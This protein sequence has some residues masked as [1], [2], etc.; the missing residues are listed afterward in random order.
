MPSFAAC[1]RTRRP[2]WSTSSPRSRARRRA[3]AEHR[4]RRIRIAAHGRRYRHAARRLGVGD[5]RSHRRRLRRHEHGHDGRAA[6]PVAL[7]RG[8]PRRVGPGTRSLDVATGTGD[9][10]IELASRGGDVVGSD[11]STGMLER[12]RSKAPGLTWEQ[13]DAMA[14]PYPDDEFDAAT[15]GFGARNF[16]D[17]RAGLARDGPRGQ[18]RRAGRDPGDHDAA[19][20]APVHVLLDL[21][22]SHGA[23]DRTAS[24]TPT[25]ISPPRSSA[26]P[27]RNALAA[28]LAAAGLPRRWLDPHRRRHHRASTTG[29]SRSGVRRSGR[30]GRRS[31]GRPR[32]RLDGATRAAPGHVRRLAWLNARRTRLRDDRRRRQAPAAAARLRRRRP[33]PGGPRRGAAGRGRRRAGALRHAGPRRRP[34]RR[35]AAPRP[36][37]RG[38]LGGSLDRRGWP[39]R[40]SST[41]RPASPAT[42]RRPK[43]P[44][45]DIDRRQQCRVRS[46]AP[47]ERHREGVPGRPGTRRRRPRRTRRRGALPAGAE[48]RRQVDA[49]QG[50][51]RVLPARRGHH[52]VGRQG[53]R[54]AHA[55]RGDAARHLDDLPGARPRPR[56]HRHRER[57]PRPRG[58]PRRVQPALPRQPA[59]ARPA[60]AVGPPRD[61]AHPVRRSACPRPRSR[62]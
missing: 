3:A 17:L 61:L 23:A 28:E 20:A 16:G 55:G 26:S 9:L 40:P 42:S 51:V 46:P 45:G 29:R 1:P 33:G 10:A 48:R 36:A 53:D 8:R 19:E 54:V 44:S 57:L 39:W 49:D 37:H 5:V 34:G 59:R 13:A 6:S 7:A 50:A 52:R 18:A 14:L 31:R 60:G 47:D 43:E 58:L 30:R 4:R 22:R 11:F 2:R 41:T 56:A 62:S 32:S 25:P 12:A 27:G 24:T 21:V 38:R 15:V 35:R